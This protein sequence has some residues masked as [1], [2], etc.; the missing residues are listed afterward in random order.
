MFM[1][2]KIL[3]WLVT[4]VICGAFAR[5]L[6]P[7]KDE[8]TLWQTSLLGCIGSFV[9]GGISYLA[10]GGENIIQASGMIMSIVGAT[11]ALYVYKNYIH[12]KLQ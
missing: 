12:P 11:V 5:W 6:V 1:M 8:M 7:G 3:W 2:I 10:W 4:G 9:G